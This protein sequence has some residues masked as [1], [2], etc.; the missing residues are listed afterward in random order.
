MTESHIDAGTIQAYLE[1]EYRVFGESPFTLRIGEP[2]EALMRTHAAHRSECSAFV[3]ACNPSG[4]RL[5]DTANEVRQSE[6]KQELER[7]A[8]PFI[9]GIGQHPSNG[10]PGEPS[11]LV[12]GI[13]LDD[14][15]AIGAQFGQNAIVWSDSDA[16]PR[17]ILLR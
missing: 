15:K 17:L 13:P 11:C 14:A 6:L 4:R 12:L 7:R 8:L 3:T 2:S 10:W 1:T 5:D 16:R 9:D